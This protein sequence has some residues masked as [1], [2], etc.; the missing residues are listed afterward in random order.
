MTCALAQAAA[1]SAVQAAGA[2]GGMLPQVIARLSDAESMGGGD[3]SRMTCAR[4]HRRRRSR[5]GGGE[6]LGGMLPHP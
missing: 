5:R 4:S 1:R 3:D 6:A 2:P